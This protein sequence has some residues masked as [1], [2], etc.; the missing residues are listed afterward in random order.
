MSTYELKLTDKYKGYITSVSDNIVEVSKNFSIKGIWTLLS[1][2]LFTDSKKMENVFHNDVY[3]KIKMCIDSDFNLDTLPIQVDSKWV[4]DHIFNL[5][6][7]YI[8]RVKRTEDFMKEDVTKEN[9]FSL[10]FDNITTGVAVYE[11]KNNGESAR[12]YVIKEYNKTSL[13]K[14]NKRKTEVLGKTIGDLV[15]DVDKTDLINIM[16]E[17]YQ[18]G[19]PKRMKAT[20]FEDKFWYVNSIFKLPTGEIVSSYLDVTEFME[21]NEKLKTSE[22]KL[23]EYIEKSPYGMFLVNE[24]GDYLEVNK[25]ATEITGYSKDELIKMNITDMIPK[26]DMEN[27]IRHFEEVK[28][29]GEK[30]GELQ[31]INKKREIGKWIIKAISV[32]NN[33]YLAYVEDV[34]EKRNLEQNLKDSEKRFRDLFE[35]APLG[36]QS[37]NK[38]GYLIDVNQAWL[39]LLG[40]E[41]EEVLGKWF[42]DFLTADGK[43]TFKT[44]F[45]KFKEAGATQSVI[46][47]LC[48][49]G[50]H[51]YV[52]FDGRVGRDSFFKFKQTHCIL[53]DITEQR[54]A[55]LKIK[56]SEE[57]LRT[58]ENI[59]HVGSFKYSLKTE[60]TIWSD[61]FFRILGYEPNSIKPDMEYFQNNIHKNDKEKFIDLFTRSEK[62]NCCFE[63]ELRIIRKDQSTRWIL[64]RGTVESD[65]SGIV[66]QMIGSIID[67]HE[68]KTS[69]EKIT[70]QLSTLKQAESIA[71]LGYFERN[72]QT[73]EYFWSDGYYRIL[74]YMPDEII[75]DKRILSFTHPDD[76]EKL[77][78]HID[79]TLKYRL[80]IDMEFRILTKTGETKYIHG[81]ASN[82]YSSDG[83][84]LKTIGIMLDVSEKV[85]LETEKRNT[86]IKLREQQKLEAIGVLA[87]GIAH[88]INNPINGIMNYGQIITDQCQDNS[89]I[90]KYAEE[91]IYETRRVSEIV[92]NLLQFSRQEKYIH[93]EENVKDII[94]QTLTLIKTMIRHDNINL[95]LKVEEDLP[96]IKCRSQQIQQVVLNLLTNARD[97][98]NKKYKEPDDNKIIIISSQK[99]SVDHTDFIR[100]TV[101][102]KG[103]GIE[104]KIRNR[105]FDPFFTTKPKEEGTGLGLSISY[106]I[107]K[108]HKGKM[109]FETVMGEG[110]R[111]NVDLPVSHDK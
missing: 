26:D 111:F 47:M 65:E 43:E 21:V 98:L 23:N 30:I 19:I 49:N 91:I 100:I 51:L 83:N 22:Y 29:S 61:E 99:V 4:I 81:R 33:K 2:N 58:T 16:K 12:D 10:L 79:Y 73:G 72:W 7:S 109:H 54:K 66:N 82:Y 3:L 24:K 67:I 41:K 34:T 44:N 105:I 20:K 62:E 46:Q 11:V 17:V 101:E 69:Q 42:G 75:E 31:F 85:K 28:E 37:L 93:R 39:D 88:E 94:S 96:L 63:M 40:Y 55:Q 80:P 97:S 90:K 74:G 104:E 89:N 27:A 53:K 56:E 103:N 78:E 86:E 52:E 92:R 70:S 48:K 38:Q 102:D 5:K 64:I 108:E 77:K 60:E 13:E 110:T 57:I 25:K 50:N 106:G 68:H 59:A 35:E 76:V 14:A 95:I 36:Y 45:M 71:D 87:S 32:S 15:K 6:K 9:M 1:S 8:I 84:P 18:S 107:I